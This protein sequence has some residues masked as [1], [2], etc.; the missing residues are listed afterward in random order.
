MK[1]II[2]K[3][4][5]FFVSSKNKYLSYNSC[6]NSFI[7][8]NKDLFDYLEQCQTNPELIESISDEVLKALTANR[9]IVNNDSDD[10]YIQELKFRTNMFTYSQQNIGITIAPTNECNFRCPYCFE[11]N[12]KSVTMADKTIDDLIAFIESHTN[13]KTMGITWYGG[14]PLLAFD[15]IKKILDKLQT[16]PIQLKQHNIITNGYYFNNE[17]IDFFLQN[18]LNFIQMTVD[19]NKKRHNRLRRD[20]DT[21]QGSYDVILAN[22]DKILERMPKTFLSI[23]VNIDKTNSND[24]LEIAKYLKERWKNYKNFE[25]YP[26][27][28]R[29]DNEDKTDLGGNAMKYNDAERFFFNLANERTQDGI[30]YYNDYYPEFSTKVCAATNI[31][32]YIIGAEGEIYKCWNDLT[33]PNKIIGYIDKKEF[34]NPWLFYDYVVSCKWHENEECIK[35]FF[36]PVCHGGCA[37]YKLRNLRQNGKYHLCQIYN[38]KESLKKCLEIYYDRKIEQKTKQI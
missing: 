5:Y 32:A 34:T 18:K 20:K 7:E 11:E 37:W 27:I 2:S 4:T 26:G 1:L 16:L 6:A 17:I 22:A 24:Y 14:E 3:Y 30:Y 35:C 13:A 31:N 21:R 9:I 25:V 28:L 8:L 36:L 15:S 33:D 10:K 29:I 19:G 12:K 23:R 38:D